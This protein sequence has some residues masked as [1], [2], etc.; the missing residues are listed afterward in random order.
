MIS[1]P[2]LARCAGGSLSKRW[3][4]MADLEVP[5]WA[6]DGTYAPLGQPEQGKDLLGGG[7]RWEPEETAKNPRSPGNPSC[8]H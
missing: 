5:L 3:V 6:G 7:E 4:A 8:P 1:L 2:G